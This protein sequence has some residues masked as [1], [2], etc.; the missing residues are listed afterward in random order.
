MSPSRC[1]PLVRTRGHRT[2]DLVG[3][4]LGV[5]DDGVHRRA[6][7]VA[8]GRQEV[9]LRSIRA[10]GGFARFVFRR[11]QVGAHDGLRAHH[12]ECEHEGALILVEVLR[13]RPGETEN[14][15]QLSV[16]PDRHAGGRARAGANHRIA[17]VLVAPQRRLG[18][19]EDRLSGPRHFRQRHRRLQRKVIQHRL[20]VLREPD[21]VHE[22]E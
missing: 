13:P 10:L 5:A 14:A 15:S 2:V 8:D 3:E 4:E 6:Q 9:R 18:I 11:P 16:G 19:E 1:F 20:H 22:A 17:P 12:A 21:G 7:F